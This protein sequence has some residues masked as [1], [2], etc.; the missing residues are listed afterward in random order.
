MSNVVFLFPRRTLKEKYHLRIKPPHFKN[1]SRIQLDVSFGRPGPQPAHRFSTLLQAPAGCITPP[2][3]ASHA[4]K[5]FCPLD[6]GLRS[7]MRTDC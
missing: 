7:H 3:P 6:D 2:P 1:L 4:Q 5:T